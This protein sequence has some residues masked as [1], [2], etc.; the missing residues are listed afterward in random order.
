MTAYHN[1]AERIARETGMG[2]VQAYRHVK[3]REELRRTRYLRPYNPNLITV[4]ER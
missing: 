4:T 1:E 3:Q 2:Y